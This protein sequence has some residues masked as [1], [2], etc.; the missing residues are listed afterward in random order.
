MADAKSIT[1]TGG[2]GK[3]KERKM[4]NKNGKTIGY[5][6][7][8]GL[9]CNSY[10]TGGKYAHTVVTLWPMAQDKDGYWNM[11]FSEKIV[12]F[13]LQS[14]QRREEDGPCFNGSAYIP[15]STSASSFTIESLKT[16]VGWY[17]M[18]VTLCDADSS[19]M[20]H[21]VEAMEFG[22]KI[23]K[24]IAKVETDICNTEPNFRAVDL[25]H[26]LLVMLDRIGILP[27]HEIKIDE[28]DIR[29]TLPGAK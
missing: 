18:H 17:A 19:W 2:T 1:R 22:L 8:Q 14:H 25:L 6:V 13:K 5:T 3:Q 28:G 29:Y 23:L 7:S 12:E 4:K 20:I 9:D 11:N 21:N 24:K 10:C 26:K 16:Y 15:H 27:A